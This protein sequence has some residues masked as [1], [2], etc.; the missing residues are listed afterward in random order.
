MAREGAAL[1]E[2][3]QGGGPAVERCD[4]DHLRGRRVAVRARQSPDGEPQ[5]RPPGA[6]LLDDER[7]LVGR[8][9]QAEGGGDGAVALA[10]AAE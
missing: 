9:G 7:A 10:P 3:G 4:G 2:F 8:V 5:Q 1:L 6:G